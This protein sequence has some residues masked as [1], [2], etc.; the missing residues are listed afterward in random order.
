MLQLCG[1]VGLCRDVRAMLIPCPIRSVSQ[2]SEEGSQ[3]WE[4][5]QAFCHFSRAHTSRASPGAQ[6]VQ[7]RHVL[8]GHSENPGWA[9]EL[10]S[11]VEHPSSSRATFYPYKNHRPWSVPS[12]CTEV[13]RDQ[14]ALVTDTA[15]ML[16]IALAH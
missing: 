11:T 7:H 9:K 14:H 5:V 6:A 2:A 12:D 1:T 8:K 16:T 4:G 10:T 13:A 15:A 3:C